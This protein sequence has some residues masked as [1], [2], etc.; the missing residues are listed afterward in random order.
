VNAGD[1]DT[2]LALAEILQAA[3]WEIVKFENIGGGV[4][5][6]IVPKKQET[7]EAG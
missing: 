4:A 5:L 1:F 7:T 2:F 6:T 3:G